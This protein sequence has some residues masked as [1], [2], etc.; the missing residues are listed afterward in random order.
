MH[1]SLVTIHRKFHFVVNLYDHIHFFDKY[2]IFDSYHQLEMHRWTNV[3]MHKTKQLEFQ[4]KYH[5]ILH[6]KPYQNNNNYKPFQLVLDEYLGK[7][8]QYYELEFQFQYFVW[9]DL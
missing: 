8:S 1:H 9:F 7:R 6:T 4:L 3:Q 2:Q 5:T